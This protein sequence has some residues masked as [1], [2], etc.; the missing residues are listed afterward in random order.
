[1]HLQNCQSTLKISFGT[2]VIL[3]NETRNSTEEYTILGQWESDPDNN[4][5]SYLSPFGSTLLNKTAGE[6]FY[7]EIDNEKIAYVVE[8]ISAAVL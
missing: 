8:Q 2:K 1:M 4:I 7:F 3:R 6:Q 5:I